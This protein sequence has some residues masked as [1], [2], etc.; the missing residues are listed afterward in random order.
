MPMFSVADFH[1]AKLLTFTFLYFISDETNFCY[2]FRGHLYLRNYVSD[3][4]F[5]PQLL[6]YNF[7]DLFSNIF[8]KCRLLLTQLLNSSTIDAGK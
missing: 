4:L 6:F 2:I 7:C 1:R 8:A 3:P 5:M